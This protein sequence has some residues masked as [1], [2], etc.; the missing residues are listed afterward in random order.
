ME[1]AE[2]RPAGA[3]G[4]S[5]DES[6]GFIEYAAPRAEKAGRAGSIGLGRE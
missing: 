6:R 3:R 4:L 1:G 2:L 5:G